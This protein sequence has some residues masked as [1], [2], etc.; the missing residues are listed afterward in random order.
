ME[1]TER[2]W[3]KVDTS[4]ECWIWTASKSRHG[5]GFFRV[6][7]KTWEAHRWIFIH[8]N[9]YVPEVVMHTCDNPSCV[10]PSHLIG[11]T[12]KD[13]QIDMRLKGRSRTATYPD[14]CP[15]GHS[16]WG[17]RELKQVKNKDLTMTARRCRVCDRERNRR[18][19]ERK[20][21]AKQEAEGGSGI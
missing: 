15:H 17:Y 5:Y 18:Y 3:N 4:K 13:N 20:R 7:G 21:K 2:F 12:R 16:E 19:N 8:I 11:G 10:R 1:I 6:D 9:G 14:V